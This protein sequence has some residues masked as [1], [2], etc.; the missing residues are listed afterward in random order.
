MYSV[1]YTLFE[2]TVPAD[3]GRN[4]EAAKGTNTATIYKV[5]STNCQ[6]YS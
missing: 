2:N 3:G 6:A 4:I 5:V 1:N